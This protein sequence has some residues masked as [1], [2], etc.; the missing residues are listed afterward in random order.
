MDRKIEYIDA[1]TSKNSE[2]LP[3]VKS[4]S[5]TVLV[6]QPYSCEDWQLGPAK[7]GDVGMDLP[8]RIKGMEHV[9]HPPTLYPPL[10]GTINYEEGWIDIPAGS[11]ARVPSGLH[12][13]MPDDAWVMVRPRSSTGFKIHLDTFGGTIDSG[14]IGTLLTL[15]YNR[16][17]LVKKT[18]CVL[19]F[20]VCGAVGLVSKSFAA[21]LA[22][23]IR[24][25]SLRI[26]DG[27][28]LAQVVL[29]PKYPLKRIINVDTLPSTI[30]GT[31]GFG[32]SGGSSTPEDQ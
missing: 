32:S 20:L 13:K 27:D 3:D 22:K 31:S 30:R 4:E 14:Y 18:L 25:G 24:W 7:D 21:R 8:V 2:S 19:K 5:G 1:R 28:R 9:E 26:K 6:M 23:S 12:I 16:Y 11:Y 15:V 29:V 17:T 10:F